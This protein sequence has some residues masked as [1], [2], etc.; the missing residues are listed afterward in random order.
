MTPK[1]VK[2]L[3]GDTKSHSK[4]EPNMIYS[5]GAILA[6][7]SD[8]D[9]VA[10][11][12]DDYD[13]DYDNDRKSNPYMSP[14]YAGDTKSCFFNLYFLQVAKLLSFMISMLVYLSHCLMQIL[15]RKCVMSCMFIF[16]YLCVSPY[17]RTSKAH[18]LCPYHVKMIERNKQR[19]SG[20]HKYSV[21][22]VI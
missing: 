14:S 4:F 3:T 7:K 11:A 10:D 8:D 21:C 17:Q 18:D 1:K 5:F 16:T 15:S 2:P 22:T 20:C 12:D 9:D 19:F 6:W 13:D